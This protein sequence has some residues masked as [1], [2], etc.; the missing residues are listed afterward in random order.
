MQ[1]RNVLLVGLFSCGLSAVARAGEPKQQPTIDDLVDKLSL[2]HTECAELT[3]HP[4]ISLSVYEKALGRLL[5][6]MLCKVNLIPYNPIEEFP[7][8]APSYPEIVTFQK[9]LQGHGVKTTV[10]FSKGQDIQ[11]ACGQLR[12][13]R[14]KK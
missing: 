6:G 12:S 3:K 7:H 11:A 2:F 8:E 10:R 5:K 1:W 14:L 4:D 13:V 9:I